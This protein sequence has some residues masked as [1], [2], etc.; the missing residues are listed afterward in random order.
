MTPK[1]KNPNYRILS[2]NQLR[3][4]PK[5]RLDTPL[6]MEDSSV[7]LS[8]TIDETSSSSSMDEEEQECN[9]DIQLHYR[10]NELNM[11]SKNKQTNSKIFNLSDNILLNIFNYVFDNSVSKKSKITSKASTFIP[12]QEQKPYPFVNILLVCKYWTNIGTKVLWKQLKFNSLN[13]MNKVYQ[14]SCPPGSMTRMSSEMTM[15]VKYFLLT[16]TLNQRIMKYLLQINLIRF[17]IVTQLMLKRNYLRI[18][19]IKI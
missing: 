14:S 9:T 1:L 19:C 6:K 12:N 17:W 4:I 8:D 5:L 10:I 11:Q 13:Q 2:P 15:G 3:E 7:M 16:T 18:A